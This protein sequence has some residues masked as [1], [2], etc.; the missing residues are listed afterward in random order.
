MAMHHSTFQLGGDGIDTQ[1]HKLFPIS[2]ADLFWILQ[3]GE[4]AIL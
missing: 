2:P 4:S 1:M 3:N